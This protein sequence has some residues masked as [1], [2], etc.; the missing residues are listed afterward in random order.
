MIINNNDSS[1]SF[2]YDNNPISIENYYGYHNWTYNSGEESGV[3]EVFYNVF[4]SNDFM[5]KECKIIFNISK[6]ESSKED[7]NSILENE[8]KYKIKELKINFKENSENSAMYEFDSY[9]IIFYNT[10]KASI[11]NII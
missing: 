7:E 1:I 9:K 3:F 6:N 10:S 5:N 2:L 4:S 8:I 11:E